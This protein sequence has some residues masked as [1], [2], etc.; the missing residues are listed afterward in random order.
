[1]MFVFGRYV[2]GN[3]LTAFAFYLPGTSSETLGNVPGYKVAFERAEN[4]YSTRERAQ[5][6]QELS[7]IIESK[8]LVVPLHQNYPVYYKSK[9]VRSV[10]D[11]LNAW[12]IS[13]QNIEIN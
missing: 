6:I 1:M 3:P 5:Y 7:G 4:S 13:I 2:D 11:E 12:T 10:G 8:N 9:R